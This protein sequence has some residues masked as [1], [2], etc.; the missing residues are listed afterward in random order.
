MLTVKGIYKDGH[1]ELNELV[2]I[3]GPHP[4][5]VTFLEGEEPV[6][7]DDHA[8]EYREALEG[9]IGIYA[10]MTPEQQR[11]FDEALHRVRQY[12]AQG[13]RVALNTIS[14]Y[15]IRRGLKHAGATTLAIKSLLPHASPPIF[16]DLNPQRMVN[17]MTA[18]CT[19]RRFSA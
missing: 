10:E 6:S 18:F 4:V 13:N 11:L 9:I 7:S 16:T 14:C 1:V 8:P 2:A 15:E 19:C 12:A 17:A 3:N 5:L